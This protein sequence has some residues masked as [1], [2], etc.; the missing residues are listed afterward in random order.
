[1]GLGACFPLDGSL[2]GCSGVI[3]E[4]GGDWVA[5]FWSDSSSALQWDNVEDG[6]SPGF[7]LFVPPN[8]RPRQLLPE[9]YA[10]LNIFAT[11]AL[12]VSPM[13]SGDTWD[14]EHPIEHLPV[15]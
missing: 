8:D 13:S 11:V 10:S 12:S 15:A 9:S 5:S 7:F 4:S 6:G 1:M 14:S 3:F 2:A